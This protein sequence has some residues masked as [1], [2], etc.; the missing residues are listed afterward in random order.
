MLTN[1]DAQSV[2]KKPL[3]IPKIEPETKKNSKS[4]SS[5]YIGVVLVLLLTIQYFYPIDIPELKTLQSNDLY[6]QISGFLI[7]G[8]VIMQWH[9]THL[10][11]TKQNTKIKKAFSSHQWL[12]ITAPLL[13]FIHST[14][15]GYGYQSALLYSFIALVAVGLFNY[16]TFKIRKKWYINSWITLHISLATICLTLIF[17]HIYI[18]YTYT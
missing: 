13:I 16:Q 3:N 1:I 15:T 8:F 2:V 6:K 17:Y 9:L 18:T 5:F 10:R 4:K 14:E 7:L 12:G 11:N